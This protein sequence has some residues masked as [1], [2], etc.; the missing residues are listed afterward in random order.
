MAKYYYDR[1]TVNITTTYTWVRYNA[2]S[3]TTYAEGPWEFMWNNEVNYGEQWNGYRSYSFNSST[4]EF[5]TS[6]YW[7]GNV[8]DAP[9]PLYHSF[10]L[11]NNLQRDTIHKSPAAQKVDF[12][13]HRRG[14]TSSTSYS[15]GSY[16]SQ[17]SGRSYSY[18]LN[19]QRNSDGYWWVRG[20]SSTSYSRGSFI[21]TIIAEDGTYPDNGRV[22]TT[23]WY[24][25][26]NK[27][28]PDFK[29]K[30]ND[31]L[32]TAEEGWVKINGVL[33]P[34]EQMWVKDNN[35]LKEV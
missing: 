16:V 23:Y 24:I 25:K 5:T 11:N 29:V 19:N 7:S 14:S 33:R 2:N 26:G 12:T 28:F 20:G 32:R 1:Y 15:R 34:I 6:S 21:D 17:T 31:Q 30:A 18:K 27:A 13:L 35:S 9:S 3:I 10:N 22:G 4:G 8:E